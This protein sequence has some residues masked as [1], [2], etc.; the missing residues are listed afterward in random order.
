MSDGG[1]DRALREREGIVFRETPERDLTLD[2]YRTGPARTSDPSSS[3]SPSPSRARG[4]PDARRWS[5]STGAPGATATPG[6]TATGSGGWPGR[7][8]PA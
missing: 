5:T 7:G 3:S 4:R 1:G 2:V 8:Y 6:S